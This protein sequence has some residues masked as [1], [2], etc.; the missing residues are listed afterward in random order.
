MTEL[1]NS[2]EIDEHRKTVDHYF[3][4]MTLGFLEWNG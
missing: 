3:R 2:L 4:L 1:T